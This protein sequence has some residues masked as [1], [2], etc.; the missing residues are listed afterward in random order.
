MGCV[1]VLRRLATKW[2]NGFDN[3]KRYWIMLLKQT[4]KNTPMSVRRFITKWKNG[5]PFNVKNVTKFFSQVSKAPEQSAPT[6]A[7]PLLC[8]P[9]WNKMTAT[10]NSCFSASTT[11]RK[12]KMNEVIQM[13]GCLK[14]PKYLKQLKL[15]S[16]QVCQNAQ[17]CQ[18]GPS[19]GKIQTLKTLIISQ[20]AATVRIGNIKTR[21]R[22]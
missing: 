11:R 21:Q 6:R 10:E 8:L 17:N 22:C 7:F 12:N 18:N 5:I 4:A 1:C 14:T 15:W 19:I 13:D 9:C 2:F 20:T 3:G 16:D